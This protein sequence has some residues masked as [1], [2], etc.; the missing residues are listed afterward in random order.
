MCS[1]IKEVSLVEIIGRI[2]GNIIEKDW[3]GEGYVY[4]NPNEF[5]EGGDVCYVPEL[6]GNFIDDAHVYFYE[7]FL[8]LAGGNDDMAA[9]IFESVTW[10][11]P[12][13]CAD[14]LGD[15]GI[16]N[17]TACNYMYDLERTNTCPKCNVINKD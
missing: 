17:C 10:E 5:H 3:S 1:K 6:T 8:E 14:N 12:E 16:I 4:K 7:D 9:F 2:K 13:T 15:I 11:H